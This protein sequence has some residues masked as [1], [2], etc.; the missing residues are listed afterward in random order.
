MKSSFAD[1]VTRLF[2]LNGT[3]DEFGQF[4]VLRAALHIGMQVM[5][6]GREEAGTDLSIGREPDATAGTAEGPARPGQ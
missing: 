3:D 5:L 6:K 2:E 4:F 1:V